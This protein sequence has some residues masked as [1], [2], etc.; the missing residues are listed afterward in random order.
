MPARS[1]SHAAPSTFSAPVSTKPT[2]NDLGIGTDEAYWNNG[3]ENLTLAPRLA[4]QPRRD[5]A[6][7]TVSVLP[8]MVT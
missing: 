1:A 4:A 6:T 3:P 2:G 8:W 5:R 7:G